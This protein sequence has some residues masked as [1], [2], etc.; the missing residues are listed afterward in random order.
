MGLPRHHQSHALRLQ[1]YPGCFPGSRASFYADEV[2]P[3][4]DIPI[5]D[6]RIERV[7]D[8]YSVYLYRSDGELTVRHGADEPGGLRYP[9]D[10]LVYL[11]ANGL[12]MERAAHH[13]K[14]LEPDFDAQA[15]ISRRSET[16]M[17]A[18]RMADHLRR[19]ELKAQFR[20]RT[21]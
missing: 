1:G 7:G 6:V 11:L 8:Q 21:R 13:V 16:D 15:E 17:A 2:Y 18:W 3:E 4:S 12:P 10:V 14:V 9:G 5:V 20:R 19:E